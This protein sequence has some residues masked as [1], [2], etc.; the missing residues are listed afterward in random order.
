MRSSVWFLNQEKAGEI[1]IETCRG[2][3]ASIASL[4]VIKNPDELDS[5]MLGSIVSQI[6]ESIC[7][8]KE[9]MPFDHTIMVY[10]HATIMKATLPKSPLNPIFAETKAKIP[11]FGGHPG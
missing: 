7:I 9:R 10:Y 4:Q 8:M 2:E 6:R 3:D 11:L 1:S 5:L